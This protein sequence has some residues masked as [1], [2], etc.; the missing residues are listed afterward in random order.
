MRAKA[1]EGVELL[2]STTTGCDWVGSWGRWTLTCNRIKVWDLKAFDCWM[3]FLGLRKDP[4][5][6]PR[7]YSL[8]LY[9]L[10]KSL[11]YFFQWCT[12]IW[13]PFCCSVVIGKVFDLVGGHSTLCGNPH[14][15]FPDRAAWFLSQICSC[16]IWKGSSTQVN[17]IRVVKHL[18]GWDQTGL[19]NQSKAS[20]TQQKVFPWL[21]WA[22]RNTWYPFGITI[23]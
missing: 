5:A 11:C 22:S 21:L 17:G 4:R 8:H 10:W 6:H 14:W 7:F 3:R 2:C 9:N 12:D 19:G 13:R 15:C 1:P 20:Q 23:S 16:I 18:D